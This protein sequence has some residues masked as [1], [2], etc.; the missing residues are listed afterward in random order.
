MEFVNI[1]SRVER[2]LKEQTTEFNI[3]SNKIIAIIGFGA[4]I[5]SATLSFIEKIKPPYLYFIILLILTSLVSIGILIFS[6]FSRKISRGMSANLMQTTIEDSTD[7]THFFKHDISYNLASF[8]EN[9][10][11]LEKVRTNLNCGLIVQTIVSLLLGLLIYIN[12]S[13]SI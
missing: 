8:N 6:L 12:N 13:H 10:P 1:A 2:K 7:E 11:I 9:S 4:A 3:L 5:I